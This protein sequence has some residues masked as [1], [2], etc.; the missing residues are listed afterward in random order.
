MTSEPQRRIAGPIILAV[1]VVIIGVLA[2]VIL[3]GPRR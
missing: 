1:A 2:W 3:Q